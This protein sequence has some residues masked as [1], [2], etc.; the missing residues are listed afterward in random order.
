[1]TYLIEYLINTGCKYWKMIMK[2]RGIPANRSC[3]LTHRSSVRG[4]VLFVSGLA[5]T[6]VSC[7]SAK[8]K[9]ICV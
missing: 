3:H 7:Q 1:M 5:V 9:G 2:N 8:K 6:F 4:N